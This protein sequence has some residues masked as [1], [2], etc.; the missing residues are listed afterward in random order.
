MTTAL[1]AATQ[2]FWSR[3]YDATSI[4]DLQRATGLS[5]SSFYLAFSDKHALF[6]RCLEH[7]AGN[8]GAALNTTAQEPLSAAALLDRLMAR[9]IELTLVRGRSRGCLLGNTAL[10]LGGRD[11]TVRRKVRGGLSA[12]ENIFAEIVRRGVVSGELAS[13]LAPGRVARVLTSNLQGILVMAK[14]GANP[15]ALADLRKAA[16]VTFTNRSSQ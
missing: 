1:E 2:V 10:E 16:L 7:Y 8:V 4:D 12:V 14:A 5:R 9:V 6:L 3:G 13:N 15:R 11:V